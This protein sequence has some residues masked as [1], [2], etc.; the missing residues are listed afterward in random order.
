MMEGRAQQTSSGPGWRRGILWLFALIFTL[1]ASGWALIWVAC[2][3]DKGE[4]GPRGSEVLWVLAWG[5]APLLLAFFLI[6][7]LWRLE[8]PPFS[9]PPRSR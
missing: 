9:R 1:A 3:F 6:F 4:W 8:G 5:L 2:A 7:V